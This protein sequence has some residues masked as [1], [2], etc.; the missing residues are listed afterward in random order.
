MFI[1]NVFRPLSDITVRVK[2]ERSEQFIATKIKRTM[3]M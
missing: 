2:D 3:V 1:L